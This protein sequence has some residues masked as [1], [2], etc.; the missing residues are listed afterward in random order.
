MAVPY[1][2][3]SFQANIIYTFVC[4]ANNAD[5]TSAPSN[6]YNMLMC[7]LMTHWQ[8]D[9]SLRLLPIGDHPEDAVCLALDPQAPGAAHDHQGR[10]QGCLGHHQLV[11]GL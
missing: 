8:S 5:G 2:A 6:R 11:G 9:L 1:V 3:A 4:N 10:T 7:A